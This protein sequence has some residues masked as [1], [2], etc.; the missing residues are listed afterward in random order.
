MTTGLFLFYATFRRIFEY[1]VA[2][3]SRRHHNPRRARALLDFAQTRT[4]G[5]VK[6]GPSRRLYGP[7]VIFWASVTRAH[8][9]VS[10]L[11]TSRA[12]YSGE[13]D[14]N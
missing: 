8:R 10:L 13:M 6:P 11:F 3:A 12:P 1:N 4:N 2:V 9:G 14:R 5:D 7:L